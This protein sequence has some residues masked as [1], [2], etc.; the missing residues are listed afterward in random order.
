MKTEKSKAKETE[1]EPEINRV[2][3]ERMVYEQLKKFDYEKASPE[4][5]KFFIDG[6]QLIIESYR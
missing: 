1:S 4:E 6:A 2:T 3:I 5:M